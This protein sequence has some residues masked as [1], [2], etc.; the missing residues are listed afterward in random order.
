MD[1]AIALGSGSAQTLNAFSPIPGLAVA[2]GL[3]TVIIQL[4][5]NVSTNRYDWL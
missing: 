1:I 4:C 3:L 5:Q 2:A